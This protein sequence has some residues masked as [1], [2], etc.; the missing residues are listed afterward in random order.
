MNRKNHENGKVKLTGVSNDRKKKFSKVIHLKNSSKVRL[1]SLNQE[2]KKKV[3]EDMTRT[4]SLVHV[5]AVRQLIGELE[6]VSDS[7]IESKLKE[8]IISLSTK[9]NVLTNYT[10]FLVVSEDLTG[11][12]SVTEQTLQVRTID[13]T[14]RQPH[15]SV[16]AHQ[17]TKT[18]ELFGFTNYGEDKLCTSIGSP[19]YVAPEVLTDE[20]YD[21]AAANMWSIGVILY[22]LLC[23]FPPFYGETPPQLFKR[24]MDCQYDFDDP[25]WDQVSDEAKDLISHLLV[26]DPKKR[27]TATQCL[28]HKWIQTMGLSTLDGLIFARR[29]GSFGPGLVL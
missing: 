23:G 10:T 4:P 6:N 16:I 11:G 2:Q 9:F 24:I 13:T 1:R 3:K 22:I 21:P 20:F 28:Q 18:V 27:F 5:M 15:K 14:P 7:S 12:D 19:G 26:K 8:D 29:S 25:V 17:E